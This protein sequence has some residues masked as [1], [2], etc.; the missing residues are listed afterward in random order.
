M[1]N[2]QYSMDYGGEAPQQSGMAVVPPQAAGQ[3]YQIVMPPQKKRISAGA[4]M[5]FGIILCG[6]ALYGAE[7]FAPP[8]YRPSTLTGSYSARSAQRHA[9]TSEIQA[10]PQR[11][12]SLRPASRTFRWQSLRGL[13]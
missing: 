4:G 8:E 13:P 1:S 2:Q 5:F 12:A 3:P 6:A 10:A 9:D 11:S 7:M